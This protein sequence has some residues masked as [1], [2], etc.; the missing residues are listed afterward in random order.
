MSIFNDY[1]FVV[2]WL[3]FSFVIMWYQLIAKHLWVVQVIQCEQKYNV[4]SVL[5]A[6]PLVGINR[7]SRILPGVNNHPIE[8]KA[9]QGK[10]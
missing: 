6:G 9:F 7:E 8:I 10:E 2:Q 5:F 4:I 3:I 1:Y